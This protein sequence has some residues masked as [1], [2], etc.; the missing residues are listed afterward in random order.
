MVPFQI[1]EIPPSPKLTSIHQRK[2]SK[3][4]CPLLLIVIH[5]IN[6]QGTTE[7]WKFIFFNEDTRSF[8]NLFVR[9]NPPT[10]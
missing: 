2:A 4:V 1:D 6:F 7:Y 3:Q 9:A 8:A 5:H 10:N